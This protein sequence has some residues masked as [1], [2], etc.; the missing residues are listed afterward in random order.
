VAVEGGLVSWMRLAWRRIG[1][2]NVMGGAIVRQGDV[3]E[4]RAL[5]TDPFNVSYIACFLYRLSYSFYRIS[6]TF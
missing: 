5:F 4:E 3:V 2:W 1:V 6:T